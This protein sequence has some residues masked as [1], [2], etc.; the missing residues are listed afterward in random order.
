MLGVI[1]TIVVVGCVIASEFRGMARR[2]GSGQM[3]WFYDESEKQ[4]YPM[5]VTTMPPD[6]GIGGRSG[7]GYRAVVVGFT[8]YKHDK[9]RR[10]IAY[11]EKY[12]SDLKRTLDEV[13]AAHAAGQIFTGSL[14]ARQ[15]QYFQ[16][17]TLV[18]R[19]NDTE[20]FPVNTDE[21]QRIMNEW[22]SWR[23][24]DGGGAVICAVD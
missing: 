14:P 3:V 1:G 24:P 5:P 15:S 17:N 18:K 12:S 13:M 20:W 4:L 2:H 6:K 10:K 19:Q 11:L 23:G 8:G 16:N 21:G 22:R 7:D 9:S